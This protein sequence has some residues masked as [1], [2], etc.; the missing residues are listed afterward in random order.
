MHLIF[1]AGHYELPMYIQILSWKGQSD[2]GKQVC[3]CGCMYVFIFG[4]Y[5]TSC[6][7]SWCCWWWCCC[8]WCQCWV[9]QEVF[10]VSCH[11]ASELRWWWL[12]F[13]FPTSTSCTCILYKHIISIH[14]HHCYCYRYIIFAFGVIVIYSC[15]VVLLFQLQ[16]SH[17]HLSFPCTSISRHLRAFQVR[18]LLLQQTFINTHIF[19]LRTAWPLVECEILEPIE[20]KRLVLDTES[21]YI[22]MP[23]VYHIFKYT[24]V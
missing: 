5:G 19:L 21:R 3:V 14:Q 20:G 12:N 9:W 22:Y 4:A 24:Y 7:W 1:G 16:F 2:V 10:S 17:Y 6:C 13:R 23:F 15:F 18:E 11:H 8:V